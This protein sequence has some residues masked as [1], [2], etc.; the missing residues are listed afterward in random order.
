MRW[1]IIALAIA[2]LACVPTSIPDRTPTPTPTVD[3]LATPQTVLVKGPPPEAQFWEYSPG[4]GTLLGDMADEL[5][6]ECADDGEFTAHIKP[7]FA[8]L[9]VEDYAEVVWR[10]DRGPGVRDWWRRSPDG[11]TLYP[12]ARA[13]LVLLAAEDIRIEVGSARVGT[14]EIRFRAPRPL[15]AFGLYGPS[16]LDCPQDSA[17]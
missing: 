5:I 12:S 11:M 17:L 13:A 6:V 8:D 4:R 1:I 14:L 2:C 9:L 7:V 16:G 3:P 15:G 10:V